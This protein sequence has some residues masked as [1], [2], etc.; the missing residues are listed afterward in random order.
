MEGTVRD[1]ADLRTSSPP[2]AHSRNGLLVLSAR[3]IERV[4][5]HLT[6]VT[7]DSAEPVEPARPIE[8]GGQLIPIRRRRRGWTLRPVAA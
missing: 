1:E 6:L 3:P 8:P 2:A 7:S 4:P 5:S